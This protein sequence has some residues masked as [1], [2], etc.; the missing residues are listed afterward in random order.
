MQY[1]CSVCGKTCGTTY[2]KAFQS[3]KR[4][5]NLLCKECW[6]KQRKD[7]ADFA[8]GLWY[9]FVH[10][11]LPILGIVAICVV[12]QIAVGFVHDKFGLSKTICGYLWLGMSAALSIPF[13]I[14]ILK[15]L[16]K[17]WSELHWFMKTVLCIVCPP[18]ILLVIIELLI[19]C[20]R[21]H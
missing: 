18:F 3:G 14:M 11:L 17:F 21:K 7:A 20:F 9:L 4:E 2:A 8:R 16:W 5:E 12:G 15:T 13:A 1:H 19:K 6:E 10:L